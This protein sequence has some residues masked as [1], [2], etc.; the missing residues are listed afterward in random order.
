MEDYEKQ[1]R[2]LLQCLITIPKKMMFV[3]GIEN[4]AEFL[5]HSLCA[6]GCLNF[7]K[8]A[9]LVD[10]ADFDQLKGIA[11]FV[12]NEAYQGDKDHWYEPENFTKHMGS[13][14]F[15][16]KV[17]SLNHKSVKK[18]GQGHTE[19]VKALA[20]ELSFSNPLHASWPMKYDNH[21]LLLFEVD[22]SSKH[23]Y[24]D[25]LENII[26]LFGFCPVF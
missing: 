7:S 12:Y 16:Q 2:A 8:A 10:N 3:H 24:Q 21:G 9:F 11:G 4:S 6:S 1:E 15:N 18:A 22:E 20:Q 14:L 13:S 23:F 17:R 26:H 19:S 25:Y 5:L